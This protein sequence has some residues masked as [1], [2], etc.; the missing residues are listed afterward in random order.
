MD[1]IKVIWKD[2]LIAESHALL[3]DI[4]EKLH[5]ELKDIGLDEREFGWETLSYLITHKLGRFPSSGEIINNES[6]KKGGKIKNHIEFKILDIK[7]SKI[8]KVEIRKSKVT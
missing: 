7:D 6:F 5:L 4:L 2:I 1:E 8:G 3:E